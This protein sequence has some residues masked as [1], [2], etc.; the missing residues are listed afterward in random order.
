MKS[1]HPQPTQDLKLLIETK[2]NAPS[3]T[4]DIVSGAARWLKAALNGAQVTYNY[5][6]CEAQNHY[7]FAAI[8]LLRSYK[9][10]PVSLDLKIAEIRGEP[11]VFAE[12][13]SLGKAEGTLFPFFG[14]VRSDDGRDLLLHYVADFIMSTES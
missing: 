11:Y 1:G 2:R 4:V 14:E 9:R 5:A 7:G 12:V 3:Q 8:T 13:R 10:Q 6:S